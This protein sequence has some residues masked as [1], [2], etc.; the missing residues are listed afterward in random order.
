MT[1]KLGARIEAD[2]SPLVEALATA[3]QALDR[4]EGRVQAANDDLAGIGETG[5]A[6][7]ASLA[8]DAGQAA[9]AMA[10]L[11]NAAEAVRAVAAAA[12]ESEGG[13]ARFAEAGGTAAATLAGLFEVANDNRGFAAIGAAGVDAARALDQ[14][15][16][17][18][19]AALAGLVQPATD[20]T[21]AVSGLGPAADG[22]GQALAGL[23]TAADDGGELERFVEATGQAGA[24]LSGLTAGDEGYARDLARHQQELS[25]LAEARARLAE[26]VRRADQ[27]N[28]E[29]SREVMEQSRRIAEDGFAA[30]LEQER[31]FWEDSQHLEEAGGQTSLQVMI[32]A[33]DEQNAVMAEELARRNQQTREQAAELRSTLDDSFKQ[34]LAPAVGLPGDTWQNN[35]DLIPI[36]GARLNA[37]IEGAGYGPVN[38][39]WQE[40]VTRFVMDG[41]DRLQEA[42][43]KAF[44]ALRDQGAA[45]FED[46]A[47]GSGAAETAASAFGAALD[48]VGKA[49]ETALGWLGSLVSGG[50]KEAEH[51]LTAAGSA[52]GQA[53]QQMAAAAQA[54]GT[55]GAAMGHAVTEGA[56]TG[57]DALSEMARLGEDVAV[58]MAAR[59]G[60]VGQSLRALGPIG[61]GAAAAIGGLWL[62]FDGEKKAEDDLTA[63]NQALARTGAGATLTAREVQALA[64]RIAATT[65][66]S[67]DEVIKAETELMQFGSVVGDAFERTLRLA[68]DLSAAFGGTL[69]GNVKLLGAALEEPEQALDALEK[70]GVRFTEAQRELI[71]GLAD[72]GRQFEAQRAILD[73]VGE[74]VGGADAA[75]RG[76]LTGRIREM[77]NAWDA[78]VADFSRSDSVIGQTAASIIA[79]ITGIINAVHEASDQSL[80]A[81][82]TRLTAERDVLRMQLESDDFGA[83]SWWPW[84]ETNAGKL[85]EQARSR[86]DEINHMLADLQ[87]RQ[88][89]QDLADAIA[90]EDRQGAEREQRAKVVAGH[91]EEIEQDLDDRLDALSSDRIDRIRAEAEAKIRVIE[92]L[93]AEAAGLGR[94]TADYDAAIAKVRDWQAAE[95][96]AANAAKR[97]AG[98]AVDANAKLVESLRHELDT[99]ELTDR[100]RAIDA[101]LRRLSADATDA[102]KEKVRELAGALFDE[103]EAAEAAEQAEEVLGHLRRQIAE[104]N[105]SAGDRAAAEAVRQLGENASEADRAMA[106]LL[107]RQ[108]QDGRDAKSVID[109]VAGSAAKYAEQLAKLNH[110]LE[111]GAIDHETYGKAADKA[112]RQMQ[113]SSR[114]W[115]DGLERSWA[116]YVSNATNSAQQVARIFNDVMSGMEDVFVKFVMTGELNFDDLTDRI[117]EDLARIFWEREIVAP[118]G[119]ALFGDGQG[120]GGGGGGGLFGSLFSGDWFSGIFHEG[121]VAGEATAFTQAPAWLFAGA[122]RYHGGGVAGLA[123]GEVPAVLKVGEIVG[124][125]EQLRQAFGGSGPIQATDASATYVINV[126]A[127]GASDP[128]ATARQVNQLVAET[129]SRLIPGIVDQATRQAQRQVVDTIQRRGGRMS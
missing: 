48:G 115:E 67:R 79:A 52:A 66:A 31:Q 81:Q 4:F 18:G 99:L 87:A 92:G 56:R 109:G 12:G 19:G 22:A 30:R 123:P 112:Y 105:L 82:I 113:E 97:E 47:A 88:A 102:Q 37:A 121:G 1:V 70:A 91:L 108:L 68:A 8:S 72:S 126:D 129:L 40:V 3:G 60:V 5:T 27:D 98:A 34:Y 26:T 42:G 100:E 117:I 124:W 54:A 15:G 101:A 45:A 69:S 107:A 25:A 116:K 118:I 10:P 65:L 35:Q 76:G 80:M 36:A 61:L 93:K 111:V 90:A 58:G 14:L 62:A 74:S 95:E 33:L 51:E 9:D 6:A 125:P 83:Q 32:A 11:G 96:A 64:E 122:P 49:A 63:L 2:V 13:F 89:Q 120:G 77:T 39:T 85:K 46:L 110:L 43:T 104:L 71:Q 53:G 44:G 119:T 127:R 59:A 128:E 38:E 86:L 57:G 78:F 84:S 106:E 7:L 41:L 17:S 20:A 75:A 28:A 29:I 50:V 24:A 23:R 114:N 16:G 103:K 73:A 21:V 94:D 55:G